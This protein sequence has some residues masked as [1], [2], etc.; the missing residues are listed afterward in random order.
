MNSIEREVLYWSGLA[1]IE[2]HKQKLICKAEQ[3]HSIWNHTQELSRI[4]TVNCESFFFNN[5]IKLEHL[6]IETLSS[7]KGL[8]NSII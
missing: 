1:Q 8:Q 5:E 3:K 6:I 2:N 7:R 4:I